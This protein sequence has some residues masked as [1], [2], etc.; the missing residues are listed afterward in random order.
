[1]IFL[2]NQTLESRLLILTFKLYVNSINKSINLKE[3]EIIKESRRP[4][5]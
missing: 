5:R 1:M 2:I 3:L 4:L